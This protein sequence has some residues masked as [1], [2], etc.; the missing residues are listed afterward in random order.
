MRP[1]SSGR[2]CRGRCK[3]LDDSRPDHR[4]RSRPSRG[5]ARP[6]GVQLAPVTGAP[7]K[8]RGVFDREPLGAAL[9]GT[10]LEV[11][12]PSGWLAL[13]LPA[14]SRALDL[15][16]RANVVQRMRRGL[17]ALPLFD[18]SDRPVRDLVI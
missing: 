12:R 8:G 7:D 14:G 15:P 13:T 6:Q 5:P 17:P 1:P 10:L 11:S 4:P 2:T 3:R 9:A 18:A 16:V